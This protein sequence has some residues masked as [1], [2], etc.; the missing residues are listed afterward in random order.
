MIVASCDN[1]VDRLITFFTVSPSV[2][3]SAA[4]LVIDYSPCSSD[5]GRRRGGIGARQGRRILHKRTCK[6][7]PD[8]SPCGVAGRK[9]CQ[10][11]GGPVSL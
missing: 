11:V 6:I 1:V 10:P 4:V 2:C 8:A 9:V 7:R 3:L 5:G